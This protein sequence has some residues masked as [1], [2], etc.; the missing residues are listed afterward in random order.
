M[1]PDADKIKEK[2]RASLFEPWILM[3]LWRYLGKTKF[4]HSCANDIGRSGHEEMSTMLMLKMIHV[5]VD[6]FG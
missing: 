3:S 4:C 1:F 6:S 2:V 5:N